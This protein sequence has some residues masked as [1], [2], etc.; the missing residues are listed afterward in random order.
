M[1]EGSQS[2]GLLPNI[3][4]EDSSINHNDEGNIFTSYKTQKILTAYVHFHVDL[5]DISK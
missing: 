2:S 5:F 3:G 4:D 1:I